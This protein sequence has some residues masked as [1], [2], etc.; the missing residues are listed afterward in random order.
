MTEKILVDSP[1]QT[2][3]LLLPPRPASETGPVAG[4]SEPVEILTY[5]PAPPDRNPMFLETRVYQGSR[6]A[7]YPLPLIDRIS[8]EPKPRLWQAVH[9]ENEWLRIMIL[10]EIGGRIHVGFDKVNGYDFFYRQNVIKPAL[11]GLAGPWISG[12]V[13]FNWPQHH[14]PGTFLP[15]SVEIEQGGDGSVTVWCSDHD[16]FTRMKGAHGVCLHPD[17]A[18][19]ELKVRLFNR[20][21]T[22]QTFLWWA[23]M[24]ARVHES[25]QSFFPPDVS[26]VTDHAKRAISKFPLSDRDYYGVRY[27]ERAERG[28]PAEEAPARYRPD[29]S[30]PPNDLSWYANIPVPTSYM[31][32]GTQGDFF[33]GYDHAAQAGVV[34]VA[35]HF[36]APGKKQWTW[37]NHEFGYAW[38]RSLTDH[39]GPYV[40]LM[41]GV[42]S[43]NQPDFSFLAPWETKKFSQYWYPIRSIGVPLAANLHAAMSLAEGPAGL[44]RI[45]VLA[46][47]GIPRAAVTVKAKGDLLRRWE[48]DL[49]IRSPLLLEIAI[50]SG[51]NL[52]ALEVEL[53]D[54]SGSLLRYA[55]AEIAPAGAPQVAVEMPS[56]EEIRS[57][58]Q[59]YLAGVHL[60]Q[61]R[62]ATRAP[63]PYWQ[64]ALRRDPGESR[65]HSALGQWRLRRGELAA[66]ERHFRSAIERLTERNPNPA[67]SEAFY[68]LGITLR[69]LGRAEEAHAALYK[70]TW[71]AALRAPAFLALAEIDAGAQRWAGAL[72]HIRR[73]L[74]AESGNNNARNLAV[75]V[76]RKLNRHQEAKAILDETRRMD[77]LDL[78]A[79][80][81]DLGESPED[82]QQCIDLALDM[83]R[84]GLKQEALQAL[85]A[86]DL[87]RRDGAAPIAAYLLA[88]LHEAC[89][90]P[91]AAQ[92]CLRQAAELPPDYVFPHRLEEMLLLEDVC[93]RRPEDPRA[94]YYLGNFLYDRRRY[95]EAIEAWEVAAARDPSFPTV[96]RNLGLAYFNVRA[97]PEKALL[98]YDK[99]LDAA[100]SDARVLYERDQLWKRAGEAPAKRLAEMNRHPDLIASR[101]D[102]ALE[103]ATLLNQTGDP[104]AALRLLT[105]RAFQPW[106][107][108]EGLALAQYARASLLTGKR[109]L[110]DGRFE[111]ALKRFQSALDP[112][113][114]LSEAWH[115]LA[116]TS[117]IY[118]W[119][120]L[121][122]RG[123]GNESAA[124][125]AFERAARQR[126]DFRQMSVQ[127]M[128]DMTYWSAMAMRSLGETEQAAELFRS[129]LAYADALER[130][131]PKIDYF[132]TSL[133]SMLL[134]KEDLEWR[135]RVEVLFLRAQG[136]LGLGSQV[137]SERLLRDLL[138]LDGNHAGAA[139]LV[140]EMRWNTHFA[141]AS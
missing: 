69:Y 118:F 32:A 37:G 10:P 125:Q 64:E 23:N 82:A 90:E 87:T 60:E 36:I 117:E 139:D 67:N 62:H 109:L 127:P 89:G 81:L 56:P 96:W 12:G 20:T 120:G 29:G 86:I 101:D 53:R 31:V 24:A 68:Y 122:E 4:W 106:E 33:G 38:D 134:F 80:R 85:G 137:E 88:A 61:Y 66:A 34:H 6:G 71:V 124:R 130:E 100:P 49:E 91:E 52:S 8:I 131:P 59:L 55:P 129:I 83:R 45:G 136:S 128:S 75:V 123:A 72:E 17:R 35:S 115:L 105:A 50:P 28:V 30:Y 92:R 116:N 107:G 63:E 99:A 9:L 126:G 95:E 42:Y 25:Y 114:N 133:P 104:S 44:A 46:T 103:Y 26:F 22:T 13:E 135:R 58:E 94:P 132:A 84:C 40:E 112:P 16:P 93:R 76:L 73:S 1:P 119:I 140:E 5:A 54:A 141:G 97:T 2:D 70:A 108:G 110:R 7:V 48:G 77:S 138:A 19:L 47:R 111:E 78:W 121:A 98:A 39:D 18:Y 113:R 41:A 57:I 43:D 51:A 3:R 11:V 79:R 102:L 65:A 15:V 27:A 74:E 21:Q 14:R